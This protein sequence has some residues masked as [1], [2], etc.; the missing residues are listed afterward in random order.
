MDREH[1]VLMGLVRPLL[2]PLGYNLEKGTLY[3]KSY[4][5]PAT[6]NASLSNR[7]LSR[8]IRLAT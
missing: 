8:L 7:V 3:K 6:Y 4:L 1:L 5:E 2:E